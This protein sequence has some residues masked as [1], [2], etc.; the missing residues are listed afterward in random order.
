MSIHKV[1]TIPTDPKGKPKITLTTEPGVYQYKDLDGKTQ[2][3]TH[4]GLES[5]VEQGQAEMTDINKLLRPAM[6]KGLLRH[7]VQFEGTGD[8]ISPG[9][10][11]TAMNTVAKARTMFESLPKAFLKEQ[12]ISNP[13]EYLAFVQ[14]PDNAKIMEKY[15]MLKL[16][17]GKNQMGLPS[18]APTPTDKDGDGLPDQTPQ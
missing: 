10:L 7:T 1:K 11:Q 2:Q 16:N 17:D 3:I 8:D 12:R 9:D 13:N 14:N 18:G 6:L 15:G 5:K 4:T